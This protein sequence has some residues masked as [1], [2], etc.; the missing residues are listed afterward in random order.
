MTAFKLQGIVAAPLLPMLP[1]HSIDWS[2]DC[3]YFIM[4]TPIS[5]RTITAMTTSR[6]VNPRTLP[7]RRPNGRR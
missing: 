6:S 2:V 5:A 1:D 3:T 4:L 7:A